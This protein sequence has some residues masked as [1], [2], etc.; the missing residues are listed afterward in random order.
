MATSRALLA[1]ALAGAAA[2]SPSQPAALVPPG[3]AATAPQAE[4]TYLGAGHLLLLH[5][6]TGAYTI[7]HLA[8]FSRPPCVGLAG[9][10]VYAGSIGVR[11]QRL[12]ALGDGA[13]LQLEPRRGSYSV[14]ICDLSEG[15]ARLRLGLRAACPV[16]VEVP[17]A[18]AGWA[19]VDVVAGSADV[20]LLHNTSAPRGATLR[21]MRFRRA[22]AAAGLL[23]AFERLPL[24]GLVWRERMGRTELSSLGRG[25]VLD[26]EPAPPNRFRIWKLN[27]RCGLADGPK[28]NSATEPPLQGPLAESTF[29][30]AHR[31]FVGVPADEGD[32]SPIFHI[33]ERSVAEG[34]Y[35]LLVCDSSKLRPAPGAP[36]PCSYVLPP[37][38]LL[39]V[40]SAGCALLHSEGVCVS[41]PGCGWCASTA[42]CQLGHR[43]APCAGG[44]PAAEWRAAGAAPPAG[45]S[46]AVALTPNSMASS[47]SAELAAGALTAGLVTPLPVQPG[48]IVII[49]E[50]TAL[51]ERHLVRAS[52]ADGTS[53]TLWDSVRKHHPRGCR[54]TRV[55]PAAAAPAAAAA[56]PAAALATA[57][58]GPAESIGTDGAA[59]E[60]ADG[61]TADASA[62]GDAPF[63]Y[64]GNDMLVQLR[65]AGRFALWRVHQPRTAE[66]AA[67]PGGAADEASE[68]LPLGLG[69]LPAPP[70]AGEAWATLL[71]TGTESCAA[72]ATPPADATAAAAEAA[73]VAAAIGG[74]AEHEA[75]RLD[76][77]D[78]YLHFESSTGRYYRYRRRAGAPPLRSALGLSGSYELVAQGLWPWLRGHQLLYAGG[79]VL[80]AW[81]PTTRKLHELQ[82]DGSR[83]APDADGANA[84][85][86][87]EVIASRGSWTLD[88]SMGGERLENLG[89][90]LIASYSASAPA[91][92][93]LRVWALSPRAADG[94]PP[95][96]ALQPAP[97]FTTPLSSPAPRQ[98]VSTAPGVF[99]EMGLAEHTY[100]LHGLSL[101]GTELMKIGAGRIG[102]SA[103]G[104]VCAHEAR[105][106][107]LSDTRCGW[108][109]SSATCVLAAPRRAGPSGDRD[110]ACPD[111]A[112]PELLG[113]AAAAWSGAPPRLGWRHEHRLSYLGDGLVLQMDPADGSYRIWWADRAALALAPPSAAG[114]A[115]PNA[116]AA[117][118][119][120]V[121]GGQWARQ[122]VSLTAVGL[123][124]L[125]L[126]LELGTSRYRVLQLGLPTNSSAGTGAGLRPSA[127]L[128]LSPRV[129]GRFA[130]SSRGWAGGL[131]GSAAPSQDMLPPTSLTE[132]P[133]PQAEKSVAKGTPLVLKEKSVAK[134]TAL[135][136][137]KGDAKKEAVKEAVKEALPKEAKRGPRSEGSFKSERA[138]DLKAVK[139]AATEVCALSSGNIERRNS[140]S[141]WHD[142]FEAE[143]TMMRLR[144]DSYTS[145]KSMQDDKDDKDLSFSKMAQLHTTAE[146]RERA[147]K[148]SE[149]L[150]NL[151]PSS[152][153]PVAPG[154]LA[155][156]PSAPRGAADSDLEGS[157][158]NDR[159]F[160]RE[161]AT[162]VKPPLAL[163]LATKSATEGEPSMKKT[164][165]GEA[166]PAAPGKRLSFK[167]DV[168]E[169]SPDKPD[170]P[171]RRS[172]K[173]DEN[174]D[175][176]AEA[177]AL[178]R[179]STS[180]PKM[181]K[182]GKE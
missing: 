110:E 41:T 182:E 181:E 155:A 151:D 75:A 173:S 159:S 47:L 146:K 17:A 170:R 104:R 65:P 46:A 121:G 171:A 25:L 60:D 172:F 89:E 97:L 67:T 77:C 31:T 19:N 13:L 161:P 95:A 120:Q 73:A 156:T 4:L 175:R 135:A 150:F 112:G 96:E 125:V 35:R 128:E 64:F 145:I 48:E 83:P 162:R 53:L 40:P 81:Q 63:A 98:I 62:S 24:S 116:R 38:P 167:L 3:D 80:L 103:T 134:G 157:F 51:A 154:T 169:K 69:L 20:V 148:K 72:A 163:K 27:P 174:S 123:D 71:F 26:Y 165:G 28:C 55:A 113:A 9:E 85:G 21:A 138:A 78:G 87:A 147:K 108:C 12:I 44:C 59:A 180:P 179:K 153:D 30:H 50:G 57:L 5:A 152:L 91:P 133:T 168:D 178:L 118:M 117:A 177:A 11:G 94:S 39:P 66:P 58:A 166:K 70:P 130:L 2:F 122:G 106:A 100:S 79:G 16:V 115:A 29:P 32:A 15:G 105:G 7:H 126:E 37:T 42:L 14:R 137:P 127:P 107:C 164:G 93:T 36:L 92:T 1:A 49:G 10:P 142:D 132:E 136:L 88:G 158:N 54:V 76:A 102:G 99:L 74:A 176:S 68:E 86:A 56:A 52:D 124:G 84:D 144:S 34:T 61:G 139:A 109:R 141:S 43:G 90:G 131:E 140:T 149:E 45:A 8:K 129:L 18:Q 101:D 143:I 23:P 114:L 33:I 6:E 111:A 82:Y 160:N 22:T 119:L